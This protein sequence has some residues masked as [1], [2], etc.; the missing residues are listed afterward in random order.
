M[1]PPG[2]ADEILLALLGESEPCEGER[3]LSDLEAEGVTTSAASTLAEL[4]RL[5]GAGMVA[6]HRGGQLRF[7]LTAEGRRRALDVAPGRLLQA[8]LLMV[9]LVGFVD[10]TARHGDGAAASAAVAL[11]S[12][13]RR[14][15]EAAGGAVVKD[16]G[17]GCLAWLPPGTETAEVVS[18]IQSQVAH[19]D[20]GSWPL[21]AACREGTVVARGG[22]LFGADVNLVARL[23]SLAEPGELVTSA[24][25]GGPDD[26]RV[27]VR[28]LTEP[29]AIRRLAL[30]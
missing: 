19:P 22:D 13:T 5:E 12:A 9:D 11:G 20:G 3:V 2:L 10:A 21:R 23:C 6:V 17:D 26:E 27:P 29:V 15:V 18:Q 4:L 28:G 25:T 7:E 8:R 1:L 16:L 14:V 30:R 24:E